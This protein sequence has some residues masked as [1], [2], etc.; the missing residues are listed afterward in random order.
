[1]STLIFDGDCGFCTTSATWIEARAGGAFQAT[2]WQ[3]LPSLEAVGLSEEQVTEA[4]Y[5]LEPGQAPREGAA[6]IS[7]AL[8][9]CGGLLALVGRV[10]VAG[11]VRPLSRVV[12]GWVSRN[13]YRMPGGTAACRV[14]P[15][16]G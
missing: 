6:A 7:Y 9:A 1:M 5:W 13:R 12:Y 14:P 3:F 16:T 15:T 4:A 11:P 10:I 2:P 8:I